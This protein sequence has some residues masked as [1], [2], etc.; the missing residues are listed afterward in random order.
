M[1]DALCAQTDPELFF[2]EP[3]DNGQ[4]GIAAKKVCGN[5]DVQ[6]QCL[7]YAMRRNEEWGIWGGTNALDRRR[8]RRAAKA[9]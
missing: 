5:C 7:E 2:P 8:M 4:K 3:G 6:A 9:A 1:D